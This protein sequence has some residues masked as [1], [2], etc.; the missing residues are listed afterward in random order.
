MSSKSI[1]ISTLKPRKIWF[2]DA[3]Q[4]LNVDRG[5][6]IGEFKGEDTTTRHYSGWSCQN[7]F[8]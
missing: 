7:H 3:V 8:A 6:L 1:S 4:R 5:E 2:D